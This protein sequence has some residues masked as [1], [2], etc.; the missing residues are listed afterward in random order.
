MGC[1]HDRVLD[2]SMKKQKNH[3]HGHQLLHR[4]QMFDGLVGKPAYVVIPNN[5][6][7][8]RR[9]NLQVVANT[10]FSKEM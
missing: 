4:Y 7:A 3:P 5:I 1:S 6:D 8:M 10:L 9:M 2:Q